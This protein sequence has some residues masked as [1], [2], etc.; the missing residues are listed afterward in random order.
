MSNL[1]TRL[2]S[3]TEYHQSNRLIGSPTKER[4]KL[5]REMMNWMFTHGD[6][7]K[8]CL[9]DPLDDLSIFGSTEEVGLS[10]KGALDLHT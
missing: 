6:I 8:L 5:E 4:L 10:R 2:G 3:I 1:A 7:G 9:N